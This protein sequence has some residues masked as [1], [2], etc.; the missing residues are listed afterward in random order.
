MCVCV[1]AWLASTTR[2]DAMHC[3]RCKK[4][5]IVKATYDTGQ[6]VARKHWCFRCNQE[7]ITLEQYAPA[8]FVFR[9]PRL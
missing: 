7:F 8:E 2:S 6:H 3:P 9:K 1:V 5:A 4:K